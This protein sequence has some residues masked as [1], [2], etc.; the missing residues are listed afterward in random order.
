[1]LRPEGVTDVHRQ[2]VEHRALGDSL[3][4]L[5]ADVR[6]REVRPSYRSQ[7][8]GQEKTE[9]C[10]FHPAIRQDSRRSV[11]WSIVR[12][13]QELLPDVRRAIAWNFSS[14]SWQCIHRM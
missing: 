6:D 14:R 5:D 11:S 10:S 13:C 1:P 8:R 9:T 2:E 12:N 3:Q 7:Q 4:S